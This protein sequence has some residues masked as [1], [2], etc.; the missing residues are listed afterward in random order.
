MITCAVCGKQNPD[1]TQ[2]CE[3]CGAELTPAAAPAPAAPAP[4]AEAAPAAEAAAPAPEAT[5][6]AEAVPAPTP[7]AAPTVPTPEATPAA[8]AEAA[9]APEAALVPEPAPVAFKPGKFT[10][11]RF[12]A[13]SSDVIP[14]QGAKLT[15]GRFDASTGPVEIDLSSLP[16]AENISRRHAEVFFE[17]GVWKV[18][19]LGS[20]NG[21]F[22]KKAGQDAYSARLV[23]PTALS[24]GDELAFGNIVVVFEDA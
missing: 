17:D 13:L 15:V 7:E 10:V 9:P 20:T 3:D 12:G 24:N 16:G 1:G 14:L 4:V 21:V 2:Y 11:K 5:P 18:K 8:P 6:A 23:E 19:D 22:V